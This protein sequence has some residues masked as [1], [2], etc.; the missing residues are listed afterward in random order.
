MRYFIINLLKHRIKNAIFNKRHICWALFV[1]ITSCGFPT[2]HN[3]SFIVSN[4]SVTNAIFVQYFF[5]ETYDTA[6]VKINPTESSTIWELTNLI[7]IESNWYHDYAI[8]INSITN[9]VGDSI[10]FNPNI[11]NNWNLSV[12]SPSYHY[13]I[14]IKDTSF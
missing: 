2:R 14:E 1:I 12:A 8:H 9:E 13:F 11:A 6:I 4:S 3:A 10:N 5:I 7:G